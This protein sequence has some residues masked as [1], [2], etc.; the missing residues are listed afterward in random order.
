MG[1][2]IVARTA[3]QREIFAAEHVTKQGYV[4]FLP[5]IAEMSGQGPHRIVTGR[6]SRPTCSLR[7]RRNGGSCSPLTASAPS[8]CAAI[9]RTPCRRVPLKNCAN[10]RTTT[11]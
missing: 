9:L 10:A 5:R 11:V 4:I 7:S 1:R 3:P 8:F 6:F 2:W